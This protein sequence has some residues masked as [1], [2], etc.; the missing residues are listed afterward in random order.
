MNKKHIITIAGR[1]GSGKSTASRELASQLGWQHFSSGDLFRALGRERGMDVLQTNIHAEGGKSD[2]DDLVDARLREMGETEDYLVIDSR[3]AWHWIPTAF[4]V[5]L[6]L[7]VH[8]AARRI[9]ASM[10]DERLVAEH[11]PENADEYAAMLQSRLESENR[12]YENLYG[13]SP[14]VLTNYDIVVDT[15]VNDAEQ[16]VNRIVEAYTTWASDKGN[17]STRIE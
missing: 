1:P 14:L 15:A 13:I 2:V 12:R 11:I 7:D 17:T 4:K 8:T 10:S 3:T 16:T 6:D 9:I 5:Y